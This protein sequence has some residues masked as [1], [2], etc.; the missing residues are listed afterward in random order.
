[1]E[2]PDFHNVLLYE[3]YLI[4]TT[5]RLFGFKK[6]IRFILG[7]PTVIFSKKKELKNTKFYFNILYNEE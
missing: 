3:I 1:M 7:L 4:L 5:K 6:M 2:R